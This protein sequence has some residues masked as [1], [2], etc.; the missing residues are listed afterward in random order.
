M[1]TCK[2]VDNYQ[3]NQSVVMATINLLLWQQPTCCYGNNQTVAMVTNIKL[4]QKTLND[5]DLYL[6]MFLSW[7]N[8][9][10]LQFCSKKCLRIKTIQCLNVK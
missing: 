3:L 6:N 4:I 9:F 5:V 7:N 1:T 8:S 10:I 2:S